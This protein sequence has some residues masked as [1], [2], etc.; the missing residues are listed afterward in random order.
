MRGP[1]NASLIIHAD[2]L[3]HTDSIKVVLSEVYSCMSGVIREKRL[4]AAPTEDG[5]SN[6]TAST[7]EC[8]PIHADILFKRADFICLTV[9]GLAAV[10]A[11]ADRDACARD[12]RGHKT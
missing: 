4:V 3:A 5:N 8:A 10:Q 6:R 9:S 1:G 7:R 12:R 2:M 11:A